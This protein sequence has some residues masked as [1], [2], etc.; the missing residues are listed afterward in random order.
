MAGAR[1]VQE[2][3]RAYRA[4]TLLPS[5][6][7][8]GAIHRQ[9]TLGHLNLFV[10]ETPEVAEE[11]AS[12]SD[13][14][15]AAGQPLGPLDGIPMSFKDNFCTE[16]VKTSCGSRMLDNF[17]APYSA[18]VVQR[19]LDQGALLLGKTNLDEFAMGSGTT[20][21]HYG[22][23][24]NLWGGPGGLDAED[25]VVAGGSS[26]G[27]AV[28]VAAGIVAASLGSDT[29]GSVRIPAAWTGVVGLKPTY[30]RLSRHGLVPLVNSLD[31]PG[32]LARTV[33]DCATVLDCLEGLDPLD[34][35]SLELPAEAAGGAGVA[36]L[37]VG[38]PQEFLCDGMSREV[39]EVW[40]EVADLLEQGGAEVTPVSLP[41]TEL[42]I[43]CYSVLNPC[44]VASNMARY[45]GLQF[46]H[47]AEHG[48]S[49]EE[50]Y[51]ETRSQGFNQVVRGRILAGNY[52]LLK[53]NYD[54]HFLQALR[55]RRL[56]LEDYLAAWRS[57]LHLLLTPVTLTDAPT[58][59]EF[60]SVDNRS[61]T[62]VQDYCT[63]PINL[64]GLPAVSL[65]ARLSA[66]G[67]PLGVQ[68]VGPALGDRLMLRAALWLQHRL[69]FPPH[70]A[71]SQ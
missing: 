23:A 71:S 5:Q 60:S 51:A 47:R 68:L 20:D 27:S 39:V 54:R 36:G 49:T 7:A 66:R 24:R 65:P 44:E 43:P 15:M 8:A 1:G 64:A 38:V 32:I 48:A 17:V 57:G 13:G 26:G 35:T 22:P 33:E 58:F 11:Q 62:A 52:F 45:D 21:S 12:Q 37:R 42:A 69:A 16:G 34:S 50:L 46:G 41:H 53:E 40:S 4:G 56:I 6:V 59:A 2:L 63:Q 3:G 25:W 30:G 28:S 9:R 18:T 31:C 70:P 19:S 55:V 61:Q 14:R 29:G 10:T 67:L